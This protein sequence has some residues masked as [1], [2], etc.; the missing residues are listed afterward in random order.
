M[1]FSWFN[2][3]AIQVRNYY[4]LKKKHLCFFQFPLDG[5]TSSFNVDYRKNIIDISF[6]LDGIIMIGPE[7]DPG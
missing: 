4:N 5:L 6:S 2:I 1:C 7:A 3:K